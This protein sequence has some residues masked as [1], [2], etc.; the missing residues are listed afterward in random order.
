MATPLGPVV[1]ELE[2]LTGVETRRIH[3]D[4]DYCGGD[5]SPGH[6]TASGTIAIT[7]VG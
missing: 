3:V 1:A 6:F 5:G 4:K 7:P 2:G